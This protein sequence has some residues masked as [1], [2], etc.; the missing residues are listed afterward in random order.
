MLTESESVGSTGFWLS[1]SR[2]ESAKYADP[3]I[4][5]QGVK[6]QP[7]TAK[8]NIFFLSKSESALWKTSSWFLKSSSS[9]SIQLSEQ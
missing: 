2:S 9:F 8:N 7:K 3:R 5:I 1:G 4:R 6:Y